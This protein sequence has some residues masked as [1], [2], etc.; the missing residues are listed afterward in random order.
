MKWCATR[1]YRPK[2]WKILKFSIDN[3]SWTIWISACAIPLPTCV[4]ICICVCNCVENRSPF[5][6]RPCERNALRSVCVCLYIQSAALKDCV[7]TMPYHDI[8][9][10][11]LIFRV[12]IVIVDKKMRFLL[13]IMLVTCRQ[14]KLGIIIGSNT[15]ESILFSLRII[16]AMA[17]VIL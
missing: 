2:F 5:D 8:Q 11:L 10:K 16:I 3:M 9:T 4:Y 13:M 15:I 14:V 12:N 7:I 1:T 6:L 17:S